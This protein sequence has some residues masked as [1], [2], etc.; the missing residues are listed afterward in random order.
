[1]LAAAGERRLHVEVLGLENERVRRGCDEHLAC[2]R[3]R[4]VER[5]RRASYINLSCAAC[6][7]TRFTFGSAEGRG[8]TGS[9]TS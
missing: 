5:V 1:M 4:D 7:F 9:G 2:A 8:K 3:A 6:G